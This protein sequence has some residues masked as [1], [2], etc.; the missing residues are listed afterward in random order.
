MARRNPKQRWHTCVD[1]VVPGAFENC[2]KCRDTRRPWMLDGEAWRP[3]PGFSNYMA[4]TFGRIKHV[5][6]GRKP[7]DCRSTRYGYQR[8]TLSDDAG[9]H[10]CP[11]VHSLVALAFLGP[12]PA[13]QNVNHKDGNKQNNRPENLEYVT[14]AENCRHAWRT[15]LSR[16]QSGSRKSRLSPELL[17]QVTALRASGLSGLE[18]ARRLGVT[19]Y[20]I[21]K[22][23]GY[24]RTEP[25]G[26]R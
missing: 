25:E 14:V 3:I 6:P 16:S 23:R 17:A 9:R 11:H 2:D 4:S 7:Q 22:A 20:A 5:S 12:L 8:V 19:R 13:G 21:A 1:D 24:R 10:R 15:G 26:E 18:V